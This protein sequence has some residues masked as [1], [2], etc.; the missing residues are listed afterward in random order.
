VPIDQVPRRPLTRGGV[1]KLYE[2]IQSFYSVMLSECYMRTLAN[3][4]VLQLEVFVEQTSLEV[5]SER[6][7]VN[8]SDFR[9]QTVP[10]CSNKI[11]ES[12]VS[13]IS[14]S[15]HCFQCF[16]IA[17]TDTVGWASGSASSQ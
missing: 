10:H 13:E 17:F 4:R 5:T 9:C 15:K 2:R 3:N 12:S 1:G 14:A 7:P 8:Q 6:V 16:D 11:T